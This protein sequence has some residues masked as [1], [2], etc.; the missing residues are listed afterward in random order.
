[1]SSERF[2][3]VALAG[4]PGT[5]KSTLACLLAKELD[6]LLLDKDEVR[7]VL[8]DGHVD[9]TVDQDDF[10]MDMLYRTAEH[11]ARSGLVSCAVIDGRTYSRRK[12]VD[13]LVAFSERAG[14]DLRLIE[15]TCAPAIARERLRSAHE[16]G[17]H[18]AADRNPELYDRLAAQ[19]EPLELF[20]LTLDTSAEPPEALARRALAHLQGGRSSGA[21]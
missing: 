17:K 6:A 20:R 10:V 18:P 19:A 8:F 15:C 1:M 12:Q 2:L 7:A 14:F 16:L 11:A 5:G 9:Y 13:Q 21:R 3:L 4:L